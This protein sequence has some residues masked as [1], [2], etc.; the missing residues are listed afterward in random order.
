VTDPTA[1]GV[2]AVD[3]PAGPTSHDVV[4]LARRALKTKKVGHTGTLDPFASGLMLLCVGPATRLSPYLTHLDKRYRAEAVLGVATDTLDREGAVIREDPAGATVETARI[5]E[6]LGALR[7]TIEQIPPVYSA[8]KIRGEAAHR[9]ARRGEAVELQPVEVHV[10]RLDLLERDG[11][12][13]V[14]DVECSSGTYIRALARDLGEAL[15]VGAHL[16]ALR[17]LSVGS[18]QVADASTVDEMSSAPTTAWSAPAEALV[19]AGVPSFEVGTGD[20]LRIG[21]GREISAPADL[22]PGE[23]DPVAAVLQGRLLAVGRVADGAFRPRRVF[24]AP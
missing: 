3:K 24:V 6:A 2:L 5:E 11:P 16:T 9:R 23:V 21:Q 12:R 14:L 1:I 22:G 18:F 15:G 4:A 7:G 8:K 19:R 17:R 10:S 13:L 20:E